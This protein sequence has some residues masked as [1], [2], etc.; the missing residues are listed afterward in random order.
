MSVGR[1]LSKDARKPSRR[2]LKRITWNRI[3]ADSDG[4]PGPP[5]RTAPLLTLAAHAGA[6]RV[7]A[8]DSHPGR[9]SVGSQVSASLHRLLPESWMQNIDATAFLQGLPVFLFLK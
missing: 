4:T 9:S 1:A 3:E 2:C 7:R 5:F 6:V 8:H